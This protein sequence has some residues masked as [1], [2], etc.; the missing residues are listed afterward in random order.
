VA[1]GDGE[2]I[3]RGCLAFLTVE[4]MRRGKSPQEACREAI[5]RL[6][7]YSIISTSAPDVSG[8]DSRA[9][10]S[11]ESSNSGGGKSRSRKSKLC[12]SL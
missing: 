7:D 11:D 8:N 9:A 10:S 3:M 6:L 2:E 5:R 12:T 4:E 1:T